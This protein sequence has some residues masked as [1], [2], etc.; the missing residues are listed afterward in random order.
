MS[1]RYNFLIPL[2]L[3]LEK[4]IFLWAS[5][6]KWGKICLSSLTS[7]NPCVDQEYYTDSFISSF[8]LGEAAAF[9]L[10]LGSSCLSVL[11][12]REWLCPPVLSYANFLISLEALLLCFSAWDSSWEVL[13]VSFRT[14]SFNQ[15]EQ[16][17]CMYYLLSSSKPGLYT[18][19]ITV[20]I[21]Y[22]EHNCTHC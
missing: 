2:R 7:S 3:E 21:I 15:L 14:E 1:K 13:S 4:D 22:P 6:G 19:N 11:G 5:M 20:Y 8:V 18:Y 16:R 9:S 17:L 12:G 10:A